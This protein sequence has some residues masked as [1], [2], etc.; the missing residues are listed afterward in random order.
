MFFDE[1]N[2]NEQIGGL[3]KEIIIDRKLDG[4]PLKDTIIII[5][6]CNPYKLKKD[7]KDTQTE[8]LKH[9]NDFCNLVYKVY[10]LP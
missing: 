8:V 4:M 6:A 5:A 10:P 1:I 2:A 7:S 9:K 3:L